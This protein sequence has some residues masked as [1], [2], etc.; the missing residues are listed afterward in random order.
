MNWQKV[1][2]FSS[3]NRSLIIGIAVL[4]GLFTYGY[5]QTY[6]LAKQIDQ[7]SSE[8]ASTTALFATAIN[9]LNEKTG[10]LEQ[11]SLGISKTL[12][13]ANQ[14]IEGVQ[15]RVGGFEQ[16]VG[17]ISNTVGTLEK[18][19]KTDP[20]LLQKYSKVFFLNEHYAPERVV[21]I[22]KEFLYSENRPEQIHER[23]FP[24]LNNLLV[25][26]KS[27]GVTIYVKSAYR[28]FD[29]QEALK[30]SYT[31]TYGAGTANQFS[32]DQGYSEHQLGTTADFITTGLNGQLYGFDKTPAYTW[33]QN[34]AFKYGFI[35]SYPQNNGYYIFEPWHWRF[36]GVALAT[37]LHD[38]NKDF[39]NLEQRQI[40]EYLVKIFD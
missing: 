2:K 39:Y 8:V 28:G 32:A 1:R 19:S 25:A 17:V 37:Y 23:V 10:A 9:T 18:L 38:Q 30:S 22:G 6:S 7:L 4:I 33:M 14:N 3:V 16:T 5:I 24:Y 31:V 29:E 13:I 11:E 34:N 35:L 36:V 15:T 20:E 12:S 27:N 40:D 21:E 26:A